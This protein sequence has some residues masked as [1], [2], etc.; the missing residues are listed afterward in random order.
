MHRLSVKMWHIFT[1][2][3][4]WHSLYLSTSL[5]SGKQE[6]YIWNFISSTLD[7][8]QPYFGFPLN[9]GS[10]TLKL[11]AHSFVNHFE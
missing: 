8:Y 7:A 1:E 10:Q 11:Y 3:A 2:Q 9:E 5:L 4:E 6:C